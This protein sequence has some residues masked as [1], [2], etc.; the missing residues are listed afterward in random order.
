MTYVTLDSY[1]VLYREDELLAVNK[2]CGVPVHGSR[3]LE[4]TP[5]T[6][7][8]MVRRHEGRLVHAAHRLDRPVSGALLLTTSREMVAY[9]GRLFENRKVKKCYLAVVRGWVEPKGTISHSLHAPKD[10]RKAASE[11]R[12]AVTH[13]ELIAK[14]ELPFPVQPYPAARYSLVSLYPETGRRHQLRMHM[15]HISHHLIGDTTY[16]RGE[17]NRLFR[18]ELG[19]RRLLLHAWSLEF[20]HPVSGRKTRIEA[21][22]DDVFSR[23]LREIGW[24]DAFSTWLGE[25]TAEAKLPR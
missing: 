25:A 1:D 21:P 12:E 11:A 22:L 16:G 8:T 7:L 24:S 6:L 3:I 14:G 17:H 4:D 18:H 19:C 15:K 10:V 13:Y 5:D 9:L 23:V 2:P 20:R